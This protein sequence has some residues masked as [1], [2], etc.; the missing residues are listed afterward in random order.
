MRYSNFLVPVLL[1]TAHRYSRHSQL[2]SVYENGPDNKRSTE[3]SPVELARSREVTGIRVGRAGGRRAVCPYLQGFRPERVG[4][5]RPESRHGL[6]GIV[7]AGPR[8]PSWALGQHLR[9]VSGLGVEHRNDL[10][11]S[12]ADRKGKETSTY[13]QFHHGVL[14]RK[15]RQRGLKQDTQ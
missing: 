6:G 12:T 2:L 1:G 4:E 10:P 11:F 5:H 14:Q 13:L 7:G 15:T 3:P 9:V 8:T